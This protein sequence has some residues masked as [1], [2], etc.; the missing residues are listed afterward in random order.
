MLLA[1]NK[2]MIRQQD[3]YSTPCIQKIHALG[4][5]AQAKRTKRTAVETKEICV[6]CR[7]K[8]SRAIHDSI[9]LAM[10]LRQVLN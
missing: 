2:T 8:D 3:S 6:L 1:H 5:A 9:A 10:R 7:G 4:L